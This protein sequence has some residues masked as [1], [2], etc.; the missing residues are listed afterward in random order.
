VATGTRSR[1]ALPSPPAT[2]DASASADGGRVA[3]PLEPTVAE[4][5]LLLQ[6][7]ETI[8]STLDLDEVLGP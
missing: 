7:I 8:S 4:Y 6:V 5:R 3:L 1:R 2:P